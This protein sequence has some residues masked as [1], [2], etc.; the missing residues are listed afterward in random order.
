VQKRLAKYPNVFLY[1]GH[2]PQ[3]ADPV[4]N[5][6]FAL[7]HF[8]FEEPHEE[9]FPALLASPLN[10]Q[11][12]TLPRAKFTRALFDLAGLRVEPL[13]ALLAGPFNLSAFP[14]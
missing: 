11:N 2:F 12:T 1:K 10:L 4:L 3:T 6:K 7:A 9:H 8:D 13:P 5:K 14:M